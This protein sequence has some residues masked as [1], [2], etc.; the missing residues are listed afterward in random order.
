MTLYE[1]LLEDLAAEQAAL[2]AVLG[3]ITDTQ[4]DL[5][6]PSVPHPG[7]RRLRLGCIRRRD[8]QMMLRISA[9]VRTSEGTLDVELD[10]KLGRR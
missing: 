1:Q 7:R 9:C 4:W 10:V 6:I 8:L 2:D 3:G 5:A